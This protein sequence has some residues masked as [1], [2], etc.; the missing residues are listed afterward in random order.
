MVDVDAL[1]VVAEPGQLAQAA[2]AQCPVGQQVLQGREDVE[3]VAANVG[4]CREEGGHHDVGT[5]L[6]HAAVCGVERFAGQRRHGGIGGIGILRLHTA[7]ET[8]ERLAEAL[9][10]LGIVA[11]GGI[12][13][14][15]EG[16][17]ERRGG[18]GERAVL[19]GGHALIHVL[20]LLAALLGAR[21][22]EVDFQVAHRLQ[23]HAKL[24]VLRAVGGGRR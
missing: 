13:H 5:V 14:A 4:I 7:L 10:G 18:H 8:V 16:A 1:E 24:E 21:G 6:V 3:R 12:A 2:V 11:V 9:K 17:L 19:G 20:H 23:G 15:V 22:V